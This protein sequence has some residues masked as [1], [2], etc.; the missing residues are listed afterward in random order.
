MNEFARFQ[1]FG[2]YYKP[3]YWLPYNQP[4]SS[5][6]TNNYAH[7]RSDML[8]NYYGPMRPDMFSYAAPRYY[9]APYYQYNNWHPTDRVKGINYDVNHLSSFA[10][11]I[12]SEPPVVV[13]NNYE[14]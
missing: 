3:G 2:S 14:T 10:S 8:T 5:Q 13:K 9:E 6:P 11:R 7:M 4:Y 12:I 1:Q